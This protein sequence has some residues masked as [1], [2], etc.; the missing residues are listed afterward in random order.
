MR[1]AF[2][3]TRADVNAQIQTNLGWIGSRPFSGA[4]RKG[5]FEGHA[6]GGGPGG[7]DS[8]LQRSFFKVLD[9][10]D[11]RLASRSMTI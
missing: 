3:S 6:E 2:A 4:R 8:K 5:D 10:A 11:M 1:S 9:R 7:Q